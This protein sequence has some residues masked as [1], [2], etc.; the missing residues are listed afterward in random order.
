M[1]QC[2]INKAG[3]KVKL[4]V[5]ENCQLHTNP[6]ASSPGAP[7]SVFQYWFVLPPEK[8]AKSRK[9]EDIG[10]LT[11]NDFYRVS[12]S[13]KESSF[14]GWIHKDHVVEWHHRQALKFSPSQGRGLAHFFKTDAEAEKAASEDDQP[15]RFKSASAREP[16]ETGGALI[17]MPLLK[18]KRAK[19]NDAEMEI[20][21]MAFMAKKPGSSPRRGAGANNEMTKSE[22]MAKST[23]DIVFVVDTTGSMEAPIAQV[24]KSIENVARQLAAD[25]KIE[26]RLRLGLVAY[27][28]WVDDMGPNG[29]E[30]LT[31]VF[32]T[33]EEGKDHQT[34]LSRIGDLR[35]AT[36]T[37]GDYAEDV[38]A[39]INTAMDTDQLKWNPLAWKQ[40]IVVGD[41]SIKGPS[42]PAGVVHPHTRKN[43]HNLTL[44]TMLARLQV[45][46]TSNL[47]AMA[48]S[49]FVL[50]SVRVKDP[51]AAQDH[52]I[53][54][55]QFAKLVEGRD[56]GGT[57]ISVNGGL[58]P[59]DFS[60]ELITVIL[61]AYA[62]HGTVGSNPTDP[63]S[64]SSKSSA[65]VPYPLLD[66]LDQFADPSEAEKM[67]FASR[68]CS[69]F[70]HE[71]NRLFVPHVFVRL[72]QLKSFNAMLQFLQGSLEDAGDPG[73]RDVAAV[74]ASLKTISATL[75]LGDTISGD[76]D[77]S[78]LLM[79]ILGFP[80]KNPIFKVSPKDLAAM[81]VTDYGD[82]QQ[83]VKAC[84]STLSTFIDN[85]NIW[86]K[87]HPDAKERDAH[88][89]IRMSDLP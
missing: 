67:H 8:G 74:V 9:L 19:V 40:I 35:C 30:Y 3:C 26:P 6:D 43:R 59:G 4:I 51:D 41:S 39:G 85:P 25:E 82:W 18:A 68:Y 54:D 57:S 88:A 23:L 52:A 65:Q 29:M 34:F 78:E 53:G 22:A 45:G 84:T 76:M 73:S 89:F 32:C 72:G 24:R 79:A 60:S 13:D 50:S 44:D 46:N 11:K 47:D 5:R 7:C 2:V 80:V 12:A 56:Y 17:V 70:D 36:V 86:M 38:L 16:E 33:L 31:Q 87:L 27:R 71:G 15:E 81:S 62:S 37:S 55:S 14:K 58:S 77:L 10:L 28:D 75:N 64:G 48:A 42:Q 21:E 63:N 83:S 1:G 66:L 49:N 61:E 20:Y 69:E